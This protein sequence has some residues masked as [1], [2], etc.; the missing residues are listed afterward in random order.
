MGF[1]RG[2]AIIYTYWYVGLPLEQAMNTSKTHV[3]YIKATINWINLIRKFFGCDTRYWILLK[4]PG[5]VS[6]ILNIYMCR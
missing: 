1:L 5:N 4:F 3:T 2:A 6:K